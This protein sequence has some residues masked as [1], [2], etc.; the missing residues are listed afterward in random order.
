MSLSK[1]KIDPRYSIMYTGSIFNG[2]DIIASE[3]STKTKNAS[4]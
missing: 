1:S 2:A 4:R 3:N